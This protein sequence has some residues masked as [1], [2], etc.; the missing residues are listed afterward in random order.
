MVLSCRVIALVMM[1]LC[2]TIDAEREFLNL[3]MNF[4]PHSVWIAIVFGVTCKSLPFL[5]LLFSACDIETGQS[6][7]ILDIEESRGQR[8]LENSLTFVRLKGIFSKLSYW[9]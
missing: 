2:V 4:F 1:V 7:V 8:K 5:R 6:N 9:T 3:Y